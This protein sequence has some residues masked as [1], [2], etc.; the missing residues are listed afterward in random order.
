MRQGTHGTPDVAGD[1]DH[2]LTSELFLLQP[3]DLFGLFTEHPR[4][5]RGARR[6]AAAAGD[7]AHR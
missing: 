3:L 6:T 7:V 1:R 5:L 2:T 4:E